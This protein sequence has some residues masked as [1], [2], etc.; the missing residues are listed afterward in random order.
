MLLVLLE[1]SRSRIELQ[2]SVDGLGGTLCGFR[3]AF[4]RSARGSRQH[5]L[6]FLGGKDF[7]DAA[8]KCGFS[9]AWAA[10]DD[11]QLVLARLPNGFLLAHRQLDVQSLFDPGNRFFHVDT[12]QRMRTG[13][14]NA[15]N[16]LCQSEL[17]SMETSQIKPRL[18]INI[19][20]NDAPILSGS[21]DRCFHDLCVDLH[22]LDC[23]FHHAGFGKAAVSF[24]SQFL[25]AVKDGGSRPVG[26]I[27]VDSQFRRQFIGGLE[28]DSSN[29][30]GQL[31]RVRLDLGD[32]FVSVSPI[33][34]DG[35]SRRNAMLG[36]KEHELTDFFLILPA[37]AD[38][39]EPL[40]PDPF[41]MQQKVRGLFED[42]QRSLVV[43][44]DDFGR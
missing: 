22:Q 16:R 31:I 13:R 4:G 15:K 21:L 8:D 6:H 38:S 18:A 2:Q 27:A 41:D 35:S 17:G 29:V 11:E 32:G 1:V 24:S 39:L 26:A 30:V 9:Y 42:F 5:T 12:W 19:F 23:M 36:Q 28:A 10:R 33:D 34:T 3:Q 44:G 43:D 7:E 37:L 14:G 40:R 25:Q 20:S